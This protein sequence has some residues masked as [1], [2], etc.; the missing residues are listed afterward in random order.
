[1]PIKASANA[2]G[3][4]PMGITTYEANSLFSNLEKIVALNDAFLRDLE[5]AMQRNDSSWANDILHHVRLPP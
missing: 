1:M 4:N 2:N 5:S 3:R